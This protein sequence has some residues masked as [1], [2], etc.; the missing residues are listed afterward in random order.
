VSKEKFLLK[1]H[2][3]HRANVTQV[4]A[5][6][7]QA[8]PSFADARFVANV[9]AKFPELELKARINWLAE[10]LKAEL[11]ADYRKAVAVILDALPAPCDPTLTDDD[12]GDFIYAPYS[13]FVAANGRTEK[14]LTL[15]LNALAEITTRFS[16]EY[17]IRPFIDA[18][19][20]RLHQQLLIWA[21]HPHYHVRRLVSEGSRPRLPW[22]G[23][24]Q[25][26]TTYGLPLLDELRNDP[27]RYVTRSVANHL[28]DIA[29]DQPH[30]VIEILKN[31]SNQNPKRVSEHN[32]ITKHALRTLVKAGHPGALELVGINL[33][34][35]IHLNSPQL[36]PE[37]PIGQALDFSFELTAQ[38]DANVLVDYAI[39]FAGRDGEL[40]GRKVYKL[41][42]VTLTAGVPVQLQKR[43]PLRGQMTTRRIYPGDHILEVLVN[44]VIRYEGKF[45]VMP[46]DSPTSATEQQ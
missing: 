45:K 3:F 23:K 9:L 43:H 32:F 10:Q 44:G 42:Q 31:W 13:A 34:T 15:S 29:K 17:S 37:V 28:N 14:H 36:T 35:K 46:I 7:K 38:S 12:F 26:P 25:V 22:G 8:W 39:K 1:D 27:T 2:L 20:D 19:P 11:P 30:V 6:I 41:K 40:T 18:F 4:A 24:L 21:D 33:S 16:A 5:D